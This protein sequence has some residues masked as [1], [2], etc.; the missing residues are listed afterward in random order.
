MDI[1]QLK[2]FVAVA[3]EGSITRASEQLHLSQPA[4]SAHIKALEETLGLTLFERTARG[5]TLTPDGQRLLA[6]AEQALAAHGE[7][8]AEA[9]R[10][11]G[12]LTGKLRLG[13]SNNSNH[14]AVGKL[15]ANVAERYPDL[16]VTLEHGT[17]AEIL[18]ALRSGALDAGFYNEG[19]DP[20]PDLSTT[21]V[22]TFGVYVVAAPGLVTTS[23]PLD[24]KALAEHAW[25]YPTASACC[26]RVAEGLFKA[27]RIRPKR[28]MNVDREDVTGSLVASGVGIGL[29]HADRASAARARGEVELLFESPGSV[30]VLFATLA[31]RAADPLC[32]ATAS[33]VSSG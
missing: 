6:K 32:V 16:E 33:L 3:R 13:A 25:I 28:V 18:A 26:G 4:T 23:T 1:H 29:L 10:I 19:G 9:T 14:D 24:W 20:D 5:V 7:L 15:L 27:H 21:E 2:T 30:R 12:R 31:S 11:K 17:S 8:M 22:S